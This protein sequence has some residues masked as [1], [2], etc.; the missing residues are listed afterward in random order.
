MKSGGPRWDDGHRVVVPTGDPDGYVRLG[1]SR[2]GVAWW[3]NDSW[4][5]R[6]F[7]T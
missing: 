4:I 5:D 3:M 6:V 1:W 7:I 2:D